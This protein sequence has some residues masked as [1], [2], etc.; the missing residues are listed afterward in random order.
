RNEKKAQMIR[1]GITGTTL[2]EIAA[3]NN[4]SVGPAIGV[5]M[6]S[7]SI[8]GVGLEPKVVGVAMALKEG[9]TSQLIDGAFGVYKITVDK[10]EEASDMADYSTYSVQVKSKLANNVSTR[11]LEALKTQAKI[12]D[13]RGNFYQ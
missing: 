12:E 1:K 4:T 3:A 9:E 7:P 10:K 2:E 6:A 11:V 13:R 5:T 8:V